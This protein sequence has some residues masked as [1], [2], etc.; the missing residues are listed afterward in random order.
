M[1]HFGHLFVDAFPIDEIKDAIAAAQHRFSVTAQVIGKTDTWSK[2]VLGIGQSAVGKSVLTG[3]DD[4]VGGYIEVRH[5]VVDF[6]RPRVEVVPQSQVEGQAAIHF[7]IV[8]P[9]ITGLPARVWKYALAGP[10]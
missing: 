2:V 1:V 6:R 8:L 10:T 7:V 4:G 5:S 9:V 3:K